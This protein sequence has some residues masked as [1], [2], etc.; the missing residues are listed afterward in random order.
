MYRSQSP[1]ALADRSPDC[2]GD[3]G[4]THVHTLFSSVSSILV[5]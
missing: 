4:V 1:V 3:N 5:D 2:S